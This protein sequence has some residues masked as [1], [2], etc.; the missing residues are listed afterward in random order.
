MQ[1]FLF[2]QVTA[3]GFIVRAPMVSIITFLPGHAPERVVS[4]L[5]LEKPYKRWATILASSQIICSRG[6][7]QVVPAVNDNHGVFHTDRKPAFFR[8]LLHIFFLFIL[9]AWG[10]RLNL[11]FVSDDDQL[12]PELWL[13]EQPANLME[14]VLFQSFV[15]LK[16]MRTRN[17]RCRWLNQ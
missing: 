1:P 6:F 3:N 5:A 9:F 15:N 17:K 14:S 12:R 8:F 11:W 13:P 2:Y 7:L 4:S 10:N 16:I